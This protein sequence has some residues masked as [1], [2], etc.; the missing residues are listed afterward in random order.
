MF[1]SGN[2]VEYKAEKVFKKG[3]DRKRYSVDMT[4]VRIFCPFCLESVAFFFC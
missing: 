3:S 2:G 1:G 4:N